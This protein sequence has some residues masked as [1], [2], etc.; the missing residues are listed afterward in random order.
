MQGFQKLG[1]FVLG[2]EIKHYHFLTLTYI[3]S[4]NI[5]LAGKHKMLRYKQVNLGEGAESKIIT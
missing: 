5:I 1:F 3:M 2:T 4:L